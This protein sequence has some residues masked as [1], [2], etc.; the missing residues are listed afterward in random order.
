MLPDAYQRKFREI[1]L[2]KIA[3]C[4]GD[5]SVLA[6]KALKETL[7]KFVSSEVISIAE[8]LG[9]LLVNRV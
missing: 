6:I 7:G 5:V 9:A 4:S 8:T 1:L 2:K 3:D